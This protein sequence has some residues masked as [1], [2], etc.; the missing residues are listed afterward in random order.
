M[1]QGTAD[2]PYMPKLII[3]LVGEKLA[4]KDEAAKYLVKKFGA[5]HIKFSHLLDGIL[6]ILDI[7][8]TR[9]NEIDLGL[10][11]REV[12]GPEVLFRALKK[13]VLESNAPAVVIN[14]IRM[15]EQETI[16]KEL[17]AKMIYI[18][19]PVELR[20]ERY[21][22]RKEKIDDGKMSFEEFARQDKE[23]LTEKGIPELGKQAKYRIDN[24]KT[25]EDLHAEIN[26]IISKIE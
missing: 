1:V 9:R 26:K 18:T 13:R 19:A 24:T 5:F 2:K 22:H 15:D 12:F 6:D 23:E 11:L 16:I 25:L 3:G 14:G 10:G 7:P 21:R 4:G 17:G 20:Y 8:K